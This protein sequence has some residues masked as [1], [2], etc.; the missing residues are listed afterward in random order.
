[1]NFKLS[2]NGIVLNKDEL[3]TKSVDIAFEILKKHDKG[4]ILIFVAAGGDGNNG[5]QLLRNQ[6]RPLPLIHS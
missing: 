3:T 6:N 1:M 2:N 4:D 5:E